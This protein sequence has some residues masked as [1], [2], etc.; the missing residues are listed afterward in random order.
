[1]IDGCLEIYILKCGYLLVYL[2]LSSRRKY[3]ELGLSAQH[4][5]NGL[6]KDTGAMFIRFGDNTK[7][8]NIVNVV[9]DTHGKTM[10]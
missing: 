9:G 8:E 3:N 1:M 7:L 10:S 5:N 4:F 6:E 2:K